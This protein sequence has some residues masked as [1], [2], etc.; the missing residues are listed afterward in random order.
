MRPGRDRR[1]RRVPGP[2]DRT[3]SQRLNEELLEPVS[4][5]GFTVVDDSRM[6]SGEAVECG[7]EL[8][9]HTHGNDLDR[10]GGVEKHERVHR[11]TGNDRVEAKFYRSHERRE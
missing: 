6:G 8:V 7:R 5:R 11:A 4:G 10:A 1:T 3:L 9:M 2:R